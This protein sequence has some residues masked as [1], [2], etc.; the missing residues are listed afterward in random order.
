MV[1]NTNLFEAPNVRISVVIPAYNRPDYL[2]EAVESALM[3]SVLP[4]EIIV[5]DNGTKQHGL[6]FSSKLVR[7]IVLPPRVGASA[8]RNAGAKAATGDYLAFLDDDDW[9][10]PNFLEFAYKRSLE[11]GASIVYGRKDIWEGGVQK[12]YKSPKESDLTIDQVLVRN[13]GTGGQNLFIKRSVFE[14]I[15]GFDP[16]LPAANDI[17]FVLDALISGYRIVCCHDAVSVLRSHEGER[18]RNDPMRRIPFVLKYRKY[19]AVSALIKRIG[20]LIARGALYRVRS[21]SQR[22]R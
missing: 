10:E 20:K 17:A 14:E 11:T 18:L 13:P 2:V 19:M 16:L 8:A 22:F 21:L 12:L 7:T 6:E 1:V 15:G 9:W 4:C 3:Q 5:A